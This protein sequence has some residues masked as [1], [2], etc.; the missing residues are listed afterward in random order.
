MSGSSG[1]MFMT[2][3]P[4]STTNTAFSEFGTDASQSHFPYTT[5]NVYDD[6]GSTVRKGSITNTIQA[7]NVWYPLGVWSAA[8]DWGLHKAGT[9]TY[10]TGT[11]TVGW[12][13]SGSHQIGGGGDIKIA[14][15]FAFNRKL[16]TNE[17]ALMAT[18]MQRHYPDIILQDNFNRTTSTNAIGNPQIGGAPTYHTGSWTT[19]GTKLNNQTAEGVISWPVNTSSYVADF[20]VGH[21]VTG[22]DSGYCVR[23]ADNN[24]FWL[25]Y[26]IN[27]QTT[28]HTRISGSYTQRATLTSAAWAPG[29]VCRVY[30]TASSIAVHR[31]AS[32]SDTFTNLGSYYDSGWM[33]NCNTRIGIRTNTTTAPFGADNIEVRPYSGVI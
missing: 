30:V 3:Y 29:D 24:N 7:L 14:E 23:L 15:V 9:N 10:T 21:S 26:L 20:T 17:R 28:L 25:V 1:E 18:Y 27:G 5:T 13:S 6:F 12:A 19:D 2:F 11:N 31:K 33:L 22:Q 32:G 16:S 4:T 8:N